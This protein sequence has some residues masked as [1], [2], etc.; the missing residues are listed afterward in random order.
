MNELKVNCK[1]KKK[2]NQT[3]ALNGA[4]TVNCGLKGLFR[5][6]TVFISKSE[7]STEHLS[8]L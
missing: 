1:N 4:A 2:Q 6:R 7:A 8:I 3:D 5:L